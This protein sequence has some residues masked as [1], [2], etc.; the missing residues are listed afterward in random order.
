MKRVAQ[1]VDRMTLAMNQ[2]CAKPMGRAMSFL[3]LILVAASSFGITTN[4]PRVPLTSES[5]SQFEEIETRELV[6]SDYRTCSRRSSRKACHLLS[7]RTF[8]SP[9]P[10]RQPTPRAIIGHRFANDLLAPIRC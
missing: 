1:P 9:A 7:C 4:L 3:M 8:R 10:P 6:S 2:P 5:E